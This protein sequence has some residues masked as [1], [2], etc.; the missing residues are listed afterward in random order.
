MA[1]PMKTTSIYTEVT[2]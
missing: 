2:N 1:Y